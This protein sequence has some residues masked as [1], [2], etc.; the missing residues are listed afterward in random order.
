MKPTINPV[1]IHPGDLKPGDVLGFKVIAVIG[2]GYDWA[3][4]RSLTDWD[5]DEVARSGDKIDRM[6]AERLFYA[7]FAAGFSYRE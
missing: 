5:D 6:A 2:E 3:A 4:Y 7:P 1:T